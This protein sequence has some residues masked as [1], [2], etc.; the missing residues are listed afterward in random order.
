M[1]FHNM[2]SSPHLSRDPCI[3]STRGLQ[4]FLAF[5]ALQQVVTQKE[6]ALFFL[7]YMP[8]DQ[9]LGQQNGL[10]ESSWRQVLMDLQ[11]VP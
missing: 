2:A 10:W 6:A 8:D 5:L 1:S 7:P 9:W 4:V 11:Q 3:H